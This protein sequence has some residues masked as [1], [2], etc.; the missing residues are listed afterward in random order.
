MTLMRDNEMPGIDN[1]Y[2]TYPFLLNV[3]PAG[4][5][6]EFDNSGISSSI[7]YIDDLRIAPEFYDRSYSDIYGHDLLGISYVDQDP[8]TSLYYGISFLNNMNR[9]RVYLSLFSEDTVTVRGF[10]LIDMIRDNPYNYTTFTNMTRDIISL[11]AGISRDRKTIEAGIQNDFITATAG[12]SDNRS[13]PATIVLNYKRLTAISLFSYHYNERNLQSDIKVFLPLSY[14]RFH[15]TAIGGYDGQFRLH[16]GILYRI[17]PR[18][19]AFMNYQRH[20]EN[21]IE[22]GLKYSRNNIFANAGCRF[23]ADSTVYEAV[24]SAGMVN[25]HLSSG[26]NMV[27]GNEDNINML[28]SINKSFFDGNLV[29]RIILGMQ[30]GDVYTTMIGT[31]LINA[32]IFL[33][34]DWNMTDKTYLIKGGLQWYFEE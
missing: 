18:W 21:H 7:F 1:Y 17:L 9:N 12:I 34:S 26:I 6:M 27:Y 11:S 19:S 22:G 23:N 16:T 4:N 33:G 30:S 29:P 31:E 2:E 25:N 10:A 8:D 15:I 5:I 14:G 3:H 13:V 32:Y 24:F 28:V 20:G